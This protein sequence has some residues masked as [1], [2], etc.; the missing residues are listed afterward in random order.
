MP[1]RTHGFVYVD[2]Q[3]P[4]PFELRLT[5][6]GGRRSL[7]RGLGIGP[8]L[9]AVP[10]NAPPTGRVA[11]GPARGP[12]PASFAGEPGVAGRLNADADLV[13]AADSL[14]PTKVG[15]DHLHTWQVDRLLAV[16]PLAPGPVLLVRT[17][18]RSTA[19]GWSPR[20]DAVLD[21]AARVEA[22]LR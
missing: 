12:G 5:V 8:L 13:R 4:R 16:E 20:A 18:H 21:L 17:F 9:Y 22:V 1:V 11:L 19:G 7:R 3:A 2:S 10:L 6:L 14:A 15:P